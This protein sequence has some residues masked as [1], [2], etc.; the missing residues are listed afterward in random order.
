LHRTK[1]LVLELLAAIC[2][3]SGGHQM[4]LS[5]FDNFKHVC[6][7]YEYFHPYSRLLWL[8]EIKSFSS[9]PPKS[10]KMQPE[11]ADCAP[12]HWRTGWNETYAS[13][14]ILA[15]LLYYVKT[16]CYPQN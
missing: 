16:W 6:G 5:A 1:T 10:S 4:I 8:V 9:F 7:R 15:Y 3:V 11:T 2:L 13:S 12:V 14:V